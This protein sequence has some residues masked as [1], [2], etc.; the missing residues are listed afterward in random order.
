MVIIA[1]LIFILGVLVGRGLKYK[2]KVIIPQ[3]KEKI[4][5]SLKPL[6]GFTVQ[7]G[8]Y[9]EENRAQSVVAKLK[10]KGYDAYLASMNLPS[11]GTLHRVRVGKFRTREDAFSTLKKLMV[12]EGL[13]DAY[14]TSR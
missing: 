3:V 2:E 11:E 5:S 10:E 14:I 4:R 8:S 1:I 6:T 9:K 13:R 7:V 12:K